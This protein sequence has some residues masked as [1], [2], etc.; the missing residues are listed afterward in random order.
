MHCG[1]CVNARLQAYN[2]CSPWSG[3]I[4]SSRVYVSD[5]RATFHFIWVWYCRGTPLLRNAITSRRIEYRGLLRAIDMARSDTYRRAA[6]ITR[7]CSFSGLSLRRRHKLNHWCCLQT[8]R[9]DQLTKL[10][11]AQLVITFPNFMEPKCSLSGRQKSTSGYNWM[12]FT[13]YLSKIHFNIILPCSPRS[14]SRFPNWNVVCISR[15]CATCPVHLILPEQHNRELLS[16]YALC[17]SSAEAP[18][19]FLT[20]EVLLGRTNVSAGPV[21]W[22]YPPDSKFITTA[23]GKASANVT[24]QPTSLLFICWHF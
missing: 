5:L 14:V 6:N 20:T 4:L 16:T 19:C 13:P 2:L 24:S 23:V 21:M 3:F 10:I 17:C 11:I 22:V 12:Q 9:D 7:S 8:V 1:H 15:I 18:L